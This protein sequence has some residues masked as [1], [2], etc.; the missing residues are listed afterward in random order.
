MKA[1]V[2]TKRK[3]GFE[4]Q[5]FPLPEVGKKDVLVKIKAAAICGSDLKIYKW[6]PW[7]ESIVKSLP[8]IPG[9]ECCGEVVEVGREVRG[10]KIGDKVAGET[11]VSCGTCWQCQHN[12]AHTCENMELF[13]HTINGCFAEYSLIPQVSV[14][15]IP[16]N[17]SFDYGS[18]LEPMGIPFRAVEKGE[19]EEEAVVVIGSGP[20]G[21]FA[22]GISKIMGAKI[23]IAIDINEKRLSIAR[24]MGAT[25]LINPKTNSVVEKV[26][27]IAKKYGRGAGVIIEASGNI[28]ALKEAFKYVRL[29]GKIIVLGQTDNPLSLKPS[30]DIVFR[31]VQIMGLFGREM[32]DT[33]NKTERI[34]SSGELNIEPIITH[35]FSLH[36]FD[37]AFKT[38]L[39]GEGCKVLL[40]PEE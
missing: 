14:R 27:D 26:K 37:E 10:I 33:W 30:S 39:S 7:C 29:G 4:Y 28:E 32:W 8:F 25:H 38:A 9:H 21:Q 12:R 6:L 13:G 20:I 24:Q 36:D 11:H 34:L 31:E 5:D 18:L 16:D 40:I 3:P 15:K 22:V 17:I 1:I 19:V 2:K 23:I 35:R